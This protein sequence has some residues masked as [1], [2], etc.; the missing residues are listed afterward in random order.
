MRRL[1]AFLSGENVRARAMRSSA[2]TVL[3]FGG[4]NFLRL[5]SNL[6]L[7]RLLFPEV[8]GLMAIVQVFLSGLQ[9]FS[10]IGIKTS[11]IQNARGDDPDF[12]NTAWTLQIGRG[13]MLWLAA[14]AMAWPASRIYDE[15]ML[16][17]LL[18]VVGLSTIIGGFTTTKIAA[19][20]RHLRLGRQVGIDLGTQAV[21]ILIMVGL[22]WA[23]RSVWA[24]VIATL[25]TAVLRNILLHR[26]LPGV[27]NRLHWNR[28][29]AREM[30]R[31]GKYIFL[32]TAAGF[33]INQGDRAI[34]G[35]FIPLGELGIYSVGMLMGTLP[36]LLGRVL[37]S[38]VIQAL[39]RM[40]PP[41]ESAANRAHIHRARRLLVAGTLAISAVL[42][43]GGIWLIELLYDPR[44]HLAGPMIVLF[45]LSMVPQLVFNGYGGALLSNGDSRRHFQLLATTA[46]VQTVLLFLTIPWLGVVG[47]ILAPGIASLATYPMKNAFTARYKANDIT[48]DMIFLALGFAVNGMAV[49]LYRAEIAQLLA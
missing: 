48:G 47:A 32:G 20:N 41:A 12:L 43:Y 28:D 9:M 27:S 25:T 24:L 21:S 35:G 29:A 23:M 13:V 17:Q 49:W 4:G 2:M 26:L 14:C 19:A 1:P 22:A 46:L 36:F 45:G 39:Y 37:N 5:L 3:G 8:F 40:K 15:P 31:F 44:Y 18:P 42:A 34:L 33:L 6:V 11:I 16:L 7:T 38:N 30:I 10:D